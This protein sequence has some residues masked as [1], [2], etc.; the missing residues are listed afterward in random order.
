MRVFPC[1]VILLVL[2][3]CIQLG[4]KPQPQNYYLLEPGVVVNNPQ[5]NR[6]STLNI[7]LKTIELAEFLDKPYLAAHDDKNLISYRQSERWAEPLNSN[8]GRVIRSNLTRSFGGAPVTLGPWEKSNAEALSIKVVIDDFAINA[9][10]IAVLNAYY[11]LAWNGQTYFK[12]YH[13]EL[14]TSINVTDQVK[15]LNSILDQFCI[16]LANNITRLV[17]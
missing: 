1:M 17:N 6:L 13:Q 10:N 8:I 16:S 3:G 12:E 4:D 11:R 2:C 5:N 9:G 14:A 15:T 7:T